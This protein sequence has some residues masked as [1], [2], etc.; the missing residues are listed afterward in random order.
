ML[1]H[2]IMSKEVWTCH[3]SESAQRCAEVMLEQ[4]VG[5]VPVVDALGRAIGVVTDRDL[6]LEVLAAKRPPSTTLEHIMSKRV[7]SCRE[8]DAL[9]AAEEL[10]ARAQKSRII[11]VDDEDR[12]TGVISLA[13]IS[14]AETS[15]RTGRLLETIARREAPARS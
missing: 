2:E 1:C 6:V 8:G 9:E 13:D 14:L 3:A 10:L 12:V 5:F 7:V 4:D 15:E 11:V